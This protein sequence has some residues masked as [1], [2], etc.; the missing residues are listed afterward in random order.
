MRRR[1]REGAASDCGRP[2]SGQSGS[3]PPER[4]RMLESTEPGVEML[5]HVAGIRRSGR[6]RISRCFRRAGKGC[7]RACSKPRLSAAPIVATDVPGCREIAR[8]DVNAFLV[9]PD[10]PV[11]LADAIDGAG[12]RSGVKAETLALPAGRWWRRSSPA[13]RIGQEVVALYDSLLGRKPAR[14]ARYGGRR[15]NSAPCNQ[16]AGITRGAWRGRSR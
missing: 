13:T 16:D 9:P 4:D 7:Q 5:G 1:R 2:R 11:A 10:D 3:I 12:A 15:L 8:H 14:I 6:G